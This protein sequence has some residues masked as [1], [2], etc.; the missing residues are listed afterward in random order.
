MFKPLYYKGKLFSRYEINENGEIKNIISNSFLKPWVI[1]SGYKVINIYSDNSKT[2]RVLIHR[3]VA[4]NF[5][6][7][8][9]EK[10]TVNHIDGN[11][12]NNHISNLEIISFTENVRHAVQTGLMA[13]GENNYNSKYTNEQIHEV[14]RLISLGSYSLTEVSNLTG[15]GYNRVVQIYHR[16]KWKQI[17]KYYDFPKLLP[18]GGNDKKE[19][20]SLKE[21]LVIYKLWELGYTNKE[22]ACIMHYP[23]THRFYA[24][25]WDLSRAKKRKEETEKFNDY[26]I[27]LIGIKRDPNLPIVQLARKKHLDQ[28]NNI[29]K[30][31]K[32]KE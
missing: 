22:I 4:E 11:K 16:A 19:A 24:A 15:V 5:I 21:R 1:N 20:F 31:I 10:M 13:S 17:S 12:L 9:P 18:I 30:P 23:K 25:M 26:P 14:C 7:E 28:Y 3:L 2:Y 32:Q 8:I 29:I 27:G 6:H